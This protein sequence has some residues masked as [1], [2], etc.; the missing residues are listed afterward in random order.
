MSSKHLCVLTHCDNAFVSNSRPI[1]EH[2]AQFLW[3]LSPGFSYTDWKARDKFVIG[4]AGLNF[5]KSVKEI[6]DYVE[7]VFLDSPEG[8]GERSESIASWIASLV[9]VLAAEYGW[10]QKEVVEMPLACVFQYIRVIRNRTGEKQI[11]FN[12]LTD[13]VKTKFLENLNK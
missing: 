10:K 5:D 4:C 13:S 11:S 2:V 9:D 6:E 12:R 8:S 3:C 1:P 7:E